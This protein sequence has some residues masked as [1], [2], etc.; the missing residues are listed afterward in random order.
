MALTCNDYFYIL[1]RNATVLMHPIDAENGW[2]EFV[3]SITDEQGVRVFDE[4][5]AAA[6]GGGGSVAYDWPH[7]A[8]GELAPKMTY[9]AAY[10]PFSWIVATGVYVDDAERIFWS[11]VQEIAAA[12][13]AIAAAVFGAS[14]L[15]TSSVFVRA[16]R[17]MAAA[18]R[19]IA[20][21]KLTTDIPF[22]DSKN[23][24][25]RHGQCCG[26]VSR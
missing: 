1:D 22:Q 10:G 20:E 24:G 11:D 6:L 2:T 16:S 4:L 15:L 23:R 18:M 8:T 3:S 25:W 17:R 7:P 19:E 12:I 9:A 13:I 21:G 26:R 5:V 14:Y